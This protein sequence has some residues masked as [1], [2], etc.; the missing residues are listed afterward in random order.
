MKILAVDDDETILDLLGEALALAGHDRIARARS[1]HEA[2]GIIAATTT[3]FDC[4]LLDIQMPGM[5]G[6]ALCR[7]VRSLHPYAQ[8]PILMLTAMSQRDYIERAFMAGATDY[9]TKPFDLI[10]LSSR[11]GMAHRLVQER[12]RVADGLHTIEKLRRELRTVPALNL[13]DPIDLGAVPRAI[14]YLAFENYI[15]SLS[16]ARSFASNV[17]AVKLRDVERLHAEHRPAEFVAR[18]RL[19]GEALS[20]AT[21]GESS[22]LSYRGNGM[23]LCVGHRRSNLTPED[24]ERH[25]N[26]SILAGQGLSVIVG[27]RSSLGAFTRFGSLQSIHKAVAAVETRAEAPVAAA[28]PRSLPQRS[29]A[30][31]RGE[32]E[33]SAYEGMLRQVLSEDLARLRGELNAG[34]GRG[35][36]RQPA[37]SRHR[38]P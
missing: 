5:D 11:I 13:A 21:E 28:A 1:A 9:I 38:V 7:E 37:P 30:R 32:Q 15:L 19:V 36:S 4:L 26:D 35:S 20:E 24:V 22:V 34:A 27:D 8:A 17:M 10:E 2:L 6:I 29:L 31:Y 18:L 12:N 23:F 25:V 3:P 16:R 14:N 33:R